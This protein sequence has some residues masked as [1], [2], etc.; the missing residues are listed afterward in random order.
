MAGMQGLGHAVRTPPGE[1]IAAGHDTTKPKCSAFSTEGVAVGSF[2]A[3]R[4][5]CSGD[6]EGRQ[7]RQEQG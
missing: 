5:R 7:A 1:K 3:R 6:Q 2:A 4:H